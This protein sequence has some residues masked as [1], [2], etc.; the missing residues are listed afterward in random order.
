[1]RLGIPEEYFTEGI[2][3]E[4][5]EALENAIAE[6]KQMGFSFKKVSL[7]HTKYALSTYYVILPAEAS[8]NLARFDG[9]R[10]GRHPELAQNYFAERG[11]GFGPEPKRR[12]ILG[13]FVLSA[14]YYDAYYK[15]AQEVRALVA[16]DFH[17]A[18]E[19][20]DALF[21]PVAPTTAFPL[22]EKVSDPLAMYL[23]DIFTI[24]VNLAGLPGISIPIKGIS[25][26]PI[27]FQL[28]GKPYREADILG[29]G[30]L[31]ENNN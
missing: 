20:V 10:Y 6:F 28:I 2:A 23:C 27:G 15:K 31:Y 29:L 24:P 30:Q 1:M 11:Y 18:F 12:I 13:T 21:A 5:G 7:P 4:V 8:A 17:K 26:M 3:P 9:I 25:G 16:R 22:G 14:G 19:E